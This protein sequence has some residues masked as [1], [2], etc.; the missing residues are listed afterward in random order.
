MKYIFYV[1]SSYCYVL[2]ICTIGLVR[3]NQSR[4]ETINVDVRLTR[5]NKIFFNSIPLHSIEFSDFSLIDKQDT[6]VM[7]V[8]GDLNNNCKA[9]HI[10]K[11]GSNLT[12]NC[13]NQNIEKFFTRLNR[14]RIMSEWRYVY[15]VQSIEYKIISLYDDE[16]K[17]Q[18]D[19]N[20][21]NNEN[22]VWY[23]KTSNFDVYS[24][25]RYDDETQ[26]QIENA[27]SDKSKSMI[28]LNQGPSYSDKNNK[29]FYQKYAI[30]FENECD[31]VKLTNKAH[32]LHSISKTNCFM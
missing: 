26:N 10:S 6:F 29:K 22:V 30:L 28:I 25:K 9:K 5:M 12:K 13:L 27:F 7:V 24:W 1:Q 8:V 32:L 11:N 18:K 2:Q 20:N 15:P 17:D 4:H 23:W 31:K 14:F 16:I 3:N 19:E 21:G